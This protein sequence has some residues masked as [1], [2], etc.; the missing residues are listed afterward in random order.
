VLAKQGLSI[1]VARDAAMCQSSGDAT[2]VGKS[3]R[4]GNEIA[5]LRSQ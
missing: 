5:T 3:P 4:Y 1:V 2:A